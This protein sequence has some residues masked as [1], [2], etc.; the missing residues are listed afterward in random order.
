MLRSVYMIMQHKEYIDMHV[1]EHNDSIK[2]LNISL[3]TKKINRK[4]HDV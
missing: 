3:F 4:C 1:N 2:S